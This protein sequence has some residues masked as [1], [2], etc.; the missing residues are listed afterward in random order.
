MRARVGYEFIELDGNSQAVKLIKPDMRLDA[1]GIAKG[2]AMDEAM[3]VL[4]SMD[5]SRAMIQ[6]GGDMAEPIRGGPGRRRP[7]EPRPMTSPIVNSG[8][9]IGSGICLCCDPLA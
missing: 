4:R 1:G 8:V 2:Y 7:R 5:M 9:L 3:N 6:G